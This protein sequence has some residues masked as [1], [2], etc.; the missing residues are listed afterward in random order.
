[1]RRIVPAASR[2]DAYNPFMSPRLFATRPSA[3]NL[4][5]RPVAAAVAGLAFAVL[6]PAWAQAPAADS[7]QAARNEPQVKHT[8]IEDEGSRVEELRVRGEVRRIT[9]TPKVGNWAP[10]EVLPAEGSRDLS[11]S[12][13]RG[14][15]GQRVW[16]VM[17]F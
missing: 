1:M 12:G 10:Y 3:F 5:C 13:G 17:S 2:A 9:V 6:Q 7:T 8:T 14:V 15:A 11:Q 4:P 16:Q